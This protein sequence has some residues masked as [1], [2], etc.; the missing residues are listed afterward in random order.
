M[1]MN[2][3][4]RF[5][6]SAVMLGLTTLMVQIILLR[7]FMVVFYGNELVIGI[8]LAN[9]MWLTGTGAFLGRYLDKWAIAA[10]LLVAYHIALSFLPLV[11]GYMLFVLRDLLFP[12]GLMLG[13]VE[14]FALSAMLLAPFCLVSGS[15]F[16]LLSRG[17]SA[18]SGNNCIGQIYGIESLGSMAGGLL[19]NFILIFFLG[20]FQCLL[21]LMLINMAAA[22]FLLHDL[23]SR[24]KWIIMVLAAGFFIAYLFFDPAGKAERHLFRGQEVVFRKET[25]YGN[26]AV[27]RN[28]D[29]LNLYENGIVLFSTNDVIHLE[30]SVHYAM[31]QHPDPQKV[32][33]LSGGESGMISEI[34]KYNVDRIDYVEINPWII[35]AGEMLTGNTSDSAL[36]IHQRDARLYIRQTDIRYDVVLINL[37]EP[38]TAQYNRYYS[39]EFFGELKRILN[40]QGIICT[41]LSSTANYISKEAR[42]INSVHYYTLKEHFEHI[43][44]IQGNK[45]YYLASAK[46]FSNR[47]TEQMEKKGIETIYVNGNYLDD[48]L[49]S[50]RAVKILSVLEDKG[51]VNHDFR[52]VSYYLNLQLW[53]SYF[54]VNES[55]ILAIIVVLLLI[56]I[57]TLKPVTLGLFTG[58]F[59]SSSVEFLLLIVF[60]VIYGYVYQMAGIIIMFFMGGLALG[61]MSVFSVFRQANR[62]AYIILILAMT[63]FC[64]LLPIMIRGLDA[65]KDYTVAVHICFM[66]ITFFCALITGMLFRVATMVQDQGISRVAGKLY[67]ADLVGSAIGVLLV[68]AFMLPLLGVDLVCLIV[69]SLNGIAAL[70]V[71]LRK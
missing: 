1:L 31:V 49:I 12:S 13:V 58:G 10:K 54:K 56:F 59:A 48:R 70:N 47:I 19:F 62:R 22:F 68:S 3:R 29:Q 66:L 60:Q 18:G 57:I 69:G 30:E 43:Q 55:V 51:I 9:W 23:R 64:L 50:E 44:L 33:L 53:L 24:V 28:A 61:S 6:L 34:L 14:V 32:L 36:H 17:A 26:L 37:P 20:P 5:Y 71:M 41:G 52:P 11:A 42:E 35:R 25:P 65:L 39:T 7:Q 45:N 27:T 8:I 2:F 40:E 4:N 38:T 63:V 67:S 15:F 16:T 21:A 46:P